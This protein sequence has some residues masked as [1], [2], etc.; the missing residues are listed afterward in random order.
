MT[1]NQPATADTEPVHV[2]AQM[3]AFERAVREHL[4]HPPAEWTVKRIDARRWYVVDHRGATIA[5][6]T[7]KKAAHE[8]IEDSTE[9]RIWD[10]NCAWYRGESTDPRVR[11]LTAD[12][13]AIV[14]QVL[15]EIG[16][17]DGPSSE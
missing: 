11:Q 6:R 16:G 13:K 7:T 4:Q 1:T 12:E 14:A 10:D 5:R 15:A 8:A 9:R 3:R 17:A 2:S